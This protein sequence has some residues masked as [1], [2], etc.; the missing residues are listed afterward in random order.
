V[1]VVIELFIRESLVEF[2][3]DDSR[4][5]TTTTRSI[6]RGSDRANWATTATTIARRAIFTA[7]AGVNVARTI[8]ERSN[9]AIWEEFLTRMH[10]NYPTRDSVRHDDTWCVLNRLEKWPAR[11]DADI[12]LKARQVGKLETPFAWRKFYICHVASYL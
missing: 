7:A 6:W 4:L 3:D 8:V 12:A 9:L 10:S 1:F 2:G 5:R 11:W